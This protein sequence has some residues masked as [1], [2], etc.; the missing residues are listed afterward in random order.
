MQT[1]LFLWCSGTT[2]EIRVNL[3]ISPLGQRVVSVLTCIICRYFKQR[4]QYRT[5]VFILFQTSMK[6]EDMS[7]VRIAVLGKV[8]VGKSGKLLHTWRVFYM[9]VG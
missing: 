4:K 1:L 2:G 5:N 3:V 6:T 9:M 7:K 8:N